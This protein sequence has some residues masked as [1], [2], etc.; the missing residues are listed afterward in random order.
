MFDFISRNTSK[1]FIISAQNK[2]QLD[3]KIFGLLFICKN[4]EPSE[5]L[6]IFSYATT[7]LPKSKWGNSWKICQHIRSSGNEWNKK[8]VSGNIGQSRVLRELLTHCPSSVWDIYIYIYIWDFTATQGATTEWYLDTIYRSFDYILIIILRGKTRNY[9]LFECPIF[10]KFSPTL[11]N[12][13]NPT[14]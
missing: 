9:W 1:T 2:L 14:P 4:S 3:C 6:E 11:T 7:F 12:I 10:V 5:I 8:N 13:S